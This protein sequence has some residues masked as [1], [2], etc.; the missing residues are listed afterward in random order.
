MLPTGVMMV[1]Y[2]DLWCGDMLTS[3]VPSVAGEVGDTAT[4]CLSDCAQCY[5]WGLYGHTLLLHKNNSLTK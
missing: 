2:A 4:D 1:K 3:V 5:R